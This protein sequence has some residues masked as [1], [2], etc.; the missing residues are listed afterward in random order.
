[1]LRATEFTRFR[2]VP[3]LPRNTR[4]IAVTNFCGGLAPRDFFPFCSLL[5]KRYKNSKNRT[6]YRFSTI[7][8]R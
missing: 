3:I 4:E 7:D 1:M 6:S 5:D 2:V 8:A